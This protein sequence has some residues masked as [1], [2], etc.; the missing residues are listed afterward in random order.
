[1]HTKKQ[2]HKDFT[3]SSQ[4]LLETLIEF[5][6]AH[7]NEQP[8]AVK[9]SAGQIAE[10]LIKSEADVAKYFGKDAESTDRDPKQKIA[11]M[12]EKM[13]NAQQCFSAPSLVAPDG[14]N[15]NRQ[16]LIDT[17]QDIRQRLA[18][19]IEIED[20]T[21]T[22]S[23][24]DHPGFGSLRRIEWLYFNIYHAERHV[25]QIWDLAAHFKH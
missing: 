13:L 2:V 25:G 10:H 14:A 11:L 15:G 1:M 18:G 6:E 5:P 24:S 17:L 19:M 22:L 4:N 23:A 3:T 16:Q 21:K 12:K 9:W 8:E 7:F 20:L